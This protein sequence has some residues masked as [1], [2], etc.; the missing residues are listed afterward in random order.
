MGWS[1]RKVLEGEPTVS[2]RLEATE[3]MWLAQNARTAL[4]RRQFEELAMRCL[5]AAHEIENRRHATE[6]IDEPRQLSRTH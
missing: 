2:L 1:M 5:D 6:T 4:M 3:L